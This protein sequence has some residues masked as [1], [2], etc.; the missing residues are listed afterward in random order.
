MQR[1]SV[2]V[3]ER[4]AAALASEAFSQ[5]VAVRL[6]E[7]RAELEAKVRGRQMVPVGLWHTTLASTCTWGELRGQRL[8]MVYAIELG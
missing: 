7:A 1:V 2:V 5:R 4:V 8:A 3:A 6:L